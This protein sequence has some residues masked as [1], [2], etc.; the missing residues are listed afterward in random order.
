MLLGKLQCQLVVAKGSVGVAQAPVGPPLTHS[1]VELLSN[2]QMHLV[3]LDGLRVVLQERVRVS[4]AVARLCLQGTIR[5][6]TGNVQGAPARIVRLGV[7]RGQH[8]G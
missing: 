2:A 1:I 6:L 5:Q 7:I 3:V 4:E 8:G